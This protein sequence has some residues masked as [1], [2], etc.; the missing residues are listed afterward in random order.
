MTIDK[1]GEEP[2]AQFDCKAVRVDGVPGVVLVIRN[3][4]HTEDAEV[5]MRWLRACIEDKWPGSTVGDGYSK[6]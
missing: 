3:L 6:H 2:R 1:P 4:R 5:V